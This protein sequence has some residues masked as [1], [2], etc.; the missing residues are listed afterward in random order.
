LNS[1]TKLGEVESDFDTDPER[2]DK[3]HHCQHHSSSSHLSRSPAR[4]QQN[5]GSPVR[6]SSR[7]PL[8]DKLRIGN[9]AAAAAQATRS[10]F[11]AASASADLPPI[12]GRPKTKNE[13]ELKQ[14]I[15]VSPSRLAGY[16]A[17]DSKEDYLQVLEDT[18]AEYERQKFN[19]M[20]TFQE[21]R[22]RVLERERKLEAEYSGKIISLSEEVLAAKRDFEERMKQFQALQ[23]VTYCTVHS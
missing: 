17:Q 10:V 18:V 16:L 14:K 1:S 21:Y 20:G 13:V 4:S 15:Q 6:Q 8:P 11:A 12:G 9:A 2:G 7:S 3:I 5:R 23:V 22:E 19:V